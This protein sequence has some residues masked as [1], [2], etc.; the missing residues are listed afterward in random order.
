VDIRK[1][2]IIAAGLTG[3]AIA[4]RVVLHQAA[5][6]MQGRTDDELDPL[7]DVPALVAHHHIDS[8]DGG[9]IHIIERGV[10]R[11]LLLIHGVAL[12]AGVWAPQL[13]QMA[14]RYRVLAMDVR[15][16]GLSTAGRDGFGRKVAARDVKSVLDH[17]DLRGT[18]VVGHSMGGMILMEFV[19]DFADDLEQ[20]IAGLVFMST[21]AY[22]VLPAG[23]L[24]VARALGRRVLARSVAGKPV[25]EL[26]L[27]GDDDLGWTLTRL[28]F[29]ARP[30]AK[31]VSQVR[32]F[33][34]EVPQSTS[35]PSIVDLLDHDARESLPSTGTPSMV[36][37]GSRDLLAPVYVARRIARL[38]PNARL[39]V[40]SG[41][42]HQLMQERPFAVA[43][44]IDDFV[45]LLPGK[46]VSGPDGV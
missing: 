1:P 6:A 12:Q 2:L 19:G 40:L 46:R 32:R 43:S 17:F 25:P 31:A 24:P 37:V 27:S 29:G 44:R 42:G 7:F 11:S 41:A 18:V 39:E 16:H 45:A 38:L 14:D 30:P 35:L 3:V 22:G 36:M 28:A 23:V 9:T 21:A 8:I 4:G 33:L 10:G 5:T 26:H 34:D 20:R 13:N 15:G